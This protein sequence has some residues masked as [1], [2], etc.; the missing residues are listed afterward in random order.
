MIRPR[1][2]IDHLVA[3]DDTTLDATAA[4]EDAGKPA[5]TAVGRDR[6]EIVEQLGRGAI[7]RVYLGVDRLLDRQVAIKELIAGDAHAAERF[8]REAKITARLQHPG[9]A[10]IHDLGRTADGSQFYAM[11]LVEGRTLQAVIDEQRS[12]RERMA[13]LPKLLAIAETVAYAHGKRIIHRDL[14]PLNVIVG[15]FGETVV[16]D[17]GLAKDLGA[18]DVDHPAAL[19]TPDEGHTVVGSVIGTPAFMPPEQARGE[20]VDERADVYAIGAIAYTMLAGAR[21][22]Q[23][24]SSDEMIA[25]VRSGPPKPLDERVPD[26]PRDLL[27]IVARAMAADPRDRY[28]SARELA[29]ELRRFQAG[30]LVVSHHYTTW[31]LLSRFLWRH[32]A[33]VATSAAFA[34][35]LAVIATVS[36]RNVVKSRNAAQ[37][38]RASAD[39]RNAALVVVEAKTALRIDPTES[40]AWLAKLAPTDHVDWREVL[41]ICAQAVSLDFTTFAWPDDLIGAKWAGDHFVGLSRSGRAMSIDPD[42]RSRLLTDVGAIEG[43]PSLS[44]HGKR[45]LVYRSGH[46]YVYDL[47][48]GV[49]DLGPLDQAVF[50][51]ADD[52]QLVAAAGQAVVVHDL[53]AD[54]ARTLDVGEDVAWATMRGGTVAA[55]TASGR[56][57]VF[58]PDGTSR[59]LPSDGSGPVLEMH[60]TRDGEH[61]LV[62][63][64]GTVCVREP[65]TSASVQIG[66]SKNE[67]AIISDDDTTIA[68]LEE[69]TLSVWTVDHP[70]LI[71]RRQVPRAMR[72]A[73]FSN[74]RIIVGGR[75]ALYVVDVNKSSMLA[76]GVQGV[77]EVA[78]LAPGGRLLA[79]DGVNAR[80]WTIPEARLAPTLDLEAWTLLPV[81]G[82]VLAAGNG[83][84]VRWNTDG[85]RDDLPLD[86]GVLALALNPWGTLA[87][88]GTDPLIRVMDPTR[89]ALVAADTNTVTGLEWSPDGSTL[90][91]SSTSTLTAWDAKTWTPTVLVHHQGRGRLAR[92]GHLLALGTGEGILLVDPASG[93]T[94]SLHDDS[95]VIGL[96]AGPDENVLM[97]GDFGGNVR[98]WD[99]ATGQSRL[100][101]RHDGH[102]WA[103]AVSP[104]G[105]LVASAGADMIV[106]VTDLDGRELYAFA[107]HEDDIDAV[108]F[109]LDGG[110][111]ISAS[112]D[113]HVRAWSLDPA[114]V[115]PTE[116]AALARWIQARFAR[117]HTGGDPTAPRSAP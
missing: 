75:R 82:A 79:G 6:Y 64:T 43:L 68:S 37:R 87:V 67:A 44:P 103:L 109:S 106:R 28:P 81:P 80:G 77:A 76:L 78:S 97:S 65:S 98:V 4:A 105:K 17:W 74:G 15:D 55:G 95:P 100:L 19:A 34:I 10:P 69:E 18:A 38:A 116:P 25:L 104:D 59:D 56:I 53:V 85:S 112:N 30:Q 45:A 12:L 63:T 57:R 61:V 72:L 114:N 94:R 70:H 108:V 48:G 83:I 91:A 92:V 16:V 111:V 66:G 50:D 60:V 51:A 110:S 47:P 9:V 88:G 62:A 90:Y 73:A 14:K 31:E 5:P 101:T 2:T 46:G 115:L 99:L 96:A 8:V 29:D 86:F 49:H 36:V 93:T 39:D 23:A 52:D 26:L 84:V 117:Q 102:V 3:R 22:H 33:I 113:G 107:G 11:K 71:L 42:G 1:S 58:R 27:A 35:V 13:L 7:G 24:T 41:D 89:S 54:R 20:A 32:K 21:P 40:I